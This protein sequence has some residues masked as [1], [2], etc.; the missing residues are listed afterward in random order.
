MNCLCPDNEGLFQ[1]DNSLFH[2]AQIFQNLF[3][4]HF[5]KFPRVI[6]CLRK[7]HEQRFRVKMI[8]WLVILQFINFLRLFKAETYFGIVRIVGGGDDNNF[9]ILSYYFTHI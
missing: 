1:Q 8:D 3:G 4:E 5:E 2:Q 6:Y 9:L 7:I